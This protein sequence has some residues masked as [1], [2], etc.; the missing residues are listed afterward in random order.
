[1]GVRD[2]LSE[3]NPHMV[4]VFG[5]THIKNLS[6]FLQQTASTNVGQNIRNRLAHWAN[7]SPSLINIS[8]VAKTLWLFTDILNTI[9]WYFLKDNIGEN[10]NN[11]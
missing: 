9:F 11:D 3:N 8:F 6:F 1:M 10:E 5:K 2:L 7:I 4:D